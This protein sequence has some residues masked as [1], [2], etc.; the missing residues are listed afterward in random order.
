MGSWHCEVEG[1]ALFSVCDKGSVPCLDEAITV[2]KL[3]TN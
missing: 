1:A 2:D 3:I